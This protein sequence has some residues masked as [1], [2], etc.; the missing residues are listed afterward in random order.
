MKYKNHLELAIDLA[1]KAGE[2]ILKIYNT[3]F[4][5]QIKED[6]SPLTLA[7]RK[8]NDIIV[9]ALR[10]KYPSHGILSEESKDDGSRL[11][12]E[13]CWIIDPLDGTKE[14]IK[15][16]DE[17]TVNIALVK[18]GEPVLGV[19]Y[20][21]ALN[22]LYYAHKGEGAY[23]KDKE[24]FKKI[25]VSQR[26]EDLILLI[27]RSHKSDMEKSFIEKNSSLIGQVK[28]LGSSL[29][30]C[31]IARAEADMYYRF[32]KTFEWDTAAQEIIVRE[33]GGVF[34]QL[35]GRAFK[36]NRENPLNEIG[37]YVLNSGKNKLL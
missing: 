27:S 22:E 1:I 33:A 19:V 15:K 11:L 5:F 20:T 24:G 16:N 18:S 34:M 26:S 35:D 29:K 31:R 28:E 6:K 13:Y 23:Y 7:D 14:F 3:D 32:G 30:G 17:F 36:Y 8:A 12:K 21:P 2:E 4:K 9:T 25:S 37:F 10:E